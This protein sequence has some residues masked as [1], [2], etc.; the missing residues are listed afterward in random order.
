LY[1]Q[2]AAG[3]LL[4]ISSWLAACWTAVCIRRVRLSWLGGSGWLGGFK[5]G[6]HA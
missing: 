6:S 2:L 5:D 1:Q 4:Q 3:L